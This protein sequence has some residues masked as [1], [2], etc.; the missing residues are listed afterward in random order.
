M[1][2]RVIHRSINPD[3]ITSSVLAGACFIGLTLPA[4]DLYKRITY[5]K[6]IEQEQSQISQT[7]QK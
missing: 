7:S 1:Q 2:R 5:I 3:T 4:Y 6:K